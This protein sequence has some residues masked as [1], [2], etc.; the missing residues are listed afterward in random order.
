MKH[1][2]YSKILRAVLACAAGVAVVVPIVA[3]AQS[4]GA[5]STPAAA[6]SAT[7]NLNVAVGGTLTPGSCTPDAGDVNFNLNKINVDSLRDKTETPLAPIVQSLTIKC[8][9]DTR[10]A[11][12]A[13]GDT[14]LPVA[15]E[16]GLTHVATGIVAEAKKGYIYDLVDQA[17]SKERIGRYVLQFRDFRYTTGSSNGTPLKA[18]VVT[19]ADKNTWVNAADSVAHASQLKADGST[20]VSFAAE[21]KVSEAVMAKLFTGNIVIGAVILPK[22]QLKVN[23]DLAFHGTTIIT[24][25]YI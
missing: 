12:S 16:T 19:S 22:S 24:L 9:A 17:T 10:V 15:S 25:S 2:Q 14:N 6:G 4:T 7:V 11:L 20:F 5:A 1:I 13:R 21:G 23:A 18:L 8:D 3:T